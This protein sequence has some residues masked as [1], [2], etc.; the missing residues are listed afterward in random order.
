MVHKHVYRWR[1]RSPQR[2]RDLINRKDQKFRG[3]DGRRR[4]KKKTLRSATKM[5][6]V[7]KMN[8]DIMML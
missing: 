1:G 5:Y 2:Q 7:V 3:E 4:E 6:S 8:K